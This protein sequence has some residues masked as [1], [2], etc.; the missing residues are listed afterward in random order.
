[1][2]N[3]PNEDFDTDYPMVAVKWID[4]TTTSQGGWHRLDEL[5]EEESEDGRYALHVYSA[6]YLVRETPIEY[7]VASSYF[8][9]HEADTGIQGLIIIPKCSV[10]SIVKADDG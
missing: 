1:M 4:S 9:D 5:I 2:A 10:L 3:S 6:G 8:I 7:W